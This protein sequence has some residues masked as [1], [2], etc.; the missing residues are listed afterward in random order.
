MSI[1]SV[2][3]LAAESSA[4]PWPYVIAG[5]VLVI[6]FG[7]MLGLMGIGKGREHS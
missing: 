5:T 4:G 1:L 3:P 6:L 7:S 2:L